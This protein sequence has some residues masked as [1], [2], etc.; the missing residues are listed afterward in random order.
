MCLCRNSAH[1]APL[2]PSNTAKN[3][4]SSG[5]ALLGEPSASLVDAVLRVIS[6]QYLPGAMARGCECGSPGSCR[7][8]R[9]P[10]ATAAYVAAR[11]VSCP[12]WAR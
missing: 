4:S 11:C 5:S 7:C 6:V 10:Y 1:L 9:W 8:V 3:P 2:C 12:G